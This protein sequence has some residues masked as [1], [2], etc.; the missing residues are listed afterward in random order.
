MH[1]PLY[2]RHTERVRLL[3][4][5]PGTSSMIRRNPEASTLSSTRTTK[6]LQSA[7]STQSA[8]CVISKTCCKLA[9]TGECYSLKA[10]LLK[11]HVWPYLTM[12][13]AYSMKGDGKV[14]RKVSFQ[15][16]LTACCS[17]RHS[18]ALSLRHSGVHDCRRSPEKDP[19]AFDC[20]QCCHEEHCPTRLR[21]SAHISRTS[22]SSVRHTELHLFLGAEW[23]SVKVS[24]TA[25]VA[26]RFDTCQCVPQL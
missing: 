23:P 9:I 25:A 24:L 11:F 26:A 6:K 18:I 15:F 4:R 7:P 8:F 22:I 20:S 12:H 21:C 19:Y 16:A 2:P 3:A 17:C 13:R 5:W 1:S 10:K 14:D